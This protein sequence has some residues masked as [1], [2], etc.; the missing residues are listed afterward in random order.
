VPKNREFKVLALVR[1]TVT[2]ELL[3]DGRRRRVYSNFNAVNRAIL[4]RYLAET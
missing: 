2:V 4:A 1:L 3:A